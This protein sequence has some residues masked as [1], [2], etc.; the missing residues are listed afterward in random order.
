MSRLAFII[1]LFSAIVLVI[2]YSISLYHDLSAFNP[3]QDLPFYLPII[4]LFPLS[5]LFFGFLS[6]LFALFT[7][8]SLSQSSQGIVGIGLSILM[9]YGGIR[10][11]DA[12]WQDLNGKGNFKRAFLISMVLFVIVSLSCLVFWGY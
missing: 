11:G 2:A 12:L 1:F 3:Y 10:L 4:A 5:L 9:L 6:P 8:I 7:G